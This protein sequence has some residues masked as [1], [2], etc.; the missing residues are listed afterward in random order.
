MPPPGMV[1]VDPFV[2][3]VEVGSGRASAAL[4]GLVDLR[5]DLG[6]DRLLDLVGQD[7]CVAQL[8]REHRDRV[9]L[10]EVLDLDGS[11]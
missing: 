5:L 9:L 1:G 7:A 2:G 3:V 10:L 8:R 4:R 6:A 11:R